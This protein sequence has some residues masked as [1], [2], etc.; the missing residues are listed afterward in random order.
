MKDEYVAYH[1]DVQKIINNLQKMNDVLASRYLE[2]A[3]WMLVN[4]SWQIK[5]YRERIDLEMAE[6]QKTLDNP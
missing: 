3:M 5:S 4:Q 1:N 6:N 2:E